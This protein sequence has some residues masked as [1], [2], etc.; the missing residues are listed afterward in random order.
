LDHLRY[1]VQ[2][3]L[4]AGQRAAVVGRHR[5][6]E[7][8]HAGIV[9][10]VFGQVTAEIGAKSAQRV[11]ALLEEGAD[12]T[13]SRMLLMDNDGNILGLFSR[14][15]HGFAKYA[16]L[17]ATTRPIDGKGTIWRA[18]STS[19]STVPV[20]GLTWPFTPSGRLQPR[21]AR[22]SPG[23]RSWSAACSIQ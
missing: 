17:V 12:P 20:L 6:A 19:I 2:L 9:R 21:S 18:F 1:P 22:R 8:H 15:R 4:D 14:G 13:G 3:A 11:A 16:P 10:H 5:T 23:S 7:N